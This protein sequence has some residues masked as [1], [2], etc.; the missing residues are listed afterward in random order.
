M[1][2]TNP[3]AANSKN[4]P[5]DSLSRARI[6]TVVGN[7]FAE[8]ALRNVGDH[9]TMFRM[10]ADQTRFKMLRGM[11]GLVR[12]AAMRSPDLPEPVDWVLLFRWPLGRE[13]SAVWNAMT[14]RDWLL[15]L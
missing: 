10:H 3:P 4:H 9:G 12:A 15:T 8:Y 5:S 13:S 7:I 14:W 2:R 6:M 1:G 11:A